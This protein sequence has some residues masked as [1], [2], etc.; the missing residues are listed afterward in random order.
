MAN[1]RNLQVAETIKRNMGMVFFQEGPYIYEDA[2]VTVTNVKLSPD[3]GQAKIYL[4][5]YNTENKLAVLQL[6]E[7][8]THR[9]RQLLAHRI[10]KH[11]RRIP[12][13][14]FYID[15]MLDEMYKLNE[16]FDNINDQEE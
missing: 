15:E 12:V 5:V 10:R 2:L 7:Q 16:L 1:K 8:Q 4:S 14:H 13:I 3:M 11:A 9:L 6:I